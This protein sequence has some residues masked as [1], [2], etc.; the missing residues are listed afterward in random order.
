M[1]F[2]F[3][4]LSMPKFDIFIPKVFY[5]AMSFYKI[6]GI[7][8]SLLTKPPLFIRLGGFGFLVTDQIRQI[9]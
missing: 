2:Y 1:Y 3:V 7:R 6:N 8:G 5:N 4:V 9:R